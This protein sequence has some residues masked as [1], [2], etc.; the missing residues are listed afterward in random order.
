MYQKENMICFIIRKQENGEHQ[1]KRR[2]GMKEPIVLTKTNKENQIIEVTAYHLENLRIVEKFPDVCSLK[3]VG[4]KVK[5]FNDLKKCPRLYEV[6]LGLTE[7][8][9]FSSLKE[10]RSIKSLN[11][12]GNYKNLIDTI[13]DMTWLKALS[14]RHCSPS[15]MRG[16]CNLVNL[17]SLSIGNTGRDSGIL[18]IFSIP[19]IR[20]LKLFIPREYEQWNLDWFL[21]SFKLNLPRLEWLEL[22]MPGHIFHPE[23]LHNLKL[24]HLSVTSKP[25]YLCKEV[26]DKD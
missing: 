19:S 9:D 12:Q 1:R 25:F 21:Y 24:R 18:E 15:S 6:S 2:V 4:G 5:N 16:L 3:L 20:R 7:V 11:I 26:A 13:Q 23:T 8:E 14:L 17:T 22:E 10:I